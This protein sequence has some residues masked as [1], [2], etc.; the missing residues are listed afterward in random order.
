MAYL[1]IK[2]F[3]SSAETS[4]VLIAL[5]SQ[6]EYEGFEEETGV[7]KAFIQKDLFDETA[8][9]KLGSQLNIQYTATELPDENW[10]AIWESNFHPVIIGNWV[11]RAEFHKPQDSSGN[12]IIITPKMSFG[13]GHHATTFMMVLQMQDIDFK[14]KHVLDFGTGT[15]VL[16]ILAHKLGAT[17]VVAIDNDNLCIENASENFIKNNIETIELKK[18]DHVDAKPGFD[19][20]L[21]NITKNVIADNFPLFNKHLINNGILLLSGLLSSDEEE[22]LLLAATH[23]FILHKK[24]QQENWICLQLIKQ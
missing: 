2:F 4:N 12:E 14:D 15:G 7:L 8:L 3:F 21:A 1:E 19:I 13:T 5:L 23:N 10:N 9:K 17:S 18:A 20:I 24:L 16:A 22:I 11:L 6:L